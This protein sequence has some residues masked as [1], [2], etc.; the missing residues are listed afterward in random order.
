MSTSSSE[1]GPRCVSNDRCTHFTWIDINDGTCFLRSGNVSKSDAIYIN[2]PTRVCGLTYYFD[3]RRINQS[4]TWDV[5]NQSRSCDFKDN[6]LSNVLSI[7]TDCSKIC[8]KTKECTHFMWFKY[9]GG[10]CYLKKGKVSKED[11]FLTNDPNMIC[12]LK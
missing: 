5:N 3:Y 6:D 11:A 1:C 2:D 10:T 8:S 12:G 9:D 4:I 7:S